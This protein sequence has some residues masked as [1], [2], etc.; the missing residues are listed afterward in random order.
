M[1]HSTKWDNEQIFL[2]VHKEQLDAQDRRA[3]VGIEIEDKTTKPTTHDP[4]K[5]HKDQKRAKWL[6]ERVSGVSDMQ[7]P[8]DPQDP[9]SH[10]VL[11]MHVV[12]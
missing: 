8:Q 5:I 9:H 11:H 12:I 3:T 6:I 10:V 4:H 1:E 7:D 2:A